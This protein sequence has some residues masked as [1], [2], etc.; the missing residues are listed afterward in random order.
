V[1]YKYSAEAW[2]LHR[3]AVR[4]VQAGVVYVVETPVSETE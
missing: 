4:A 2:T 3:E 1:Q